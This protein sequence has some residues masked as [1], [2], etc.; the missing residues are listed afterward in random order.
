M[1]VCAWVCVCMCVCVCVCSKT[2]IAPEL[3]RLPTRPLPLHYANAPFTPSALP[4]SSVD[5]EALGVCNG[6][7]RFLP[8]WFISHGG[9]MVEMMAVMMM[10]TVA[11]SDTIVSRILGSAPAST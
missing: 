4:T 7:C 11:L 5:D 3:Y 9:M 8:F 10:M 2:G 1:L 6:C